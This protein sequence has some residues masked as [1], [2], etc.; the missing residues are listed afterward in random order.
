MPFHTPITEAK[1]IAHRPARKTQRLGRLREH[2]RHAP[3]RR[4]LDAV[5][6]AP[7]LA[8]HPSRIE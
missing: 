7:C 5:Q 6:D 2:L 4:G 1:E 3:E 8:Q